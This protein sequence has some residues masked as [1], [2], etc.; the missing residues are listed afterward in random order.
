MK[1]KIIAIF[2][3]CLIIPFASISQH[4]AP[5]ER[6]KVG[7]VLSGGGAKGFAYIGLLKVIQ[8]AQ[9]PVD[10]IGGTSIGSIM[11]GLYAVGYSPE[12]IERVVRS[13]NWG[14]LLIDRIDR[15]YISYEEKEFGEKSI[16]T[17]PFKSKKLALSS[18]LYKGQ[19]IDLLLNRYFSPAYNISDFNKLPTPFLCI[20]TDLITGEPVEIRSGNLA[21]AIRASMSIPGYF[22]PVEYH[23][24][25]LCDGG[26][27][28]NFPVRNVKEMGADIIVAGDVQPGLR[29]SPEELSSITAILDQ[30]LTFGREDA[31]KDA[32]GLSDIYVPLD[33]PYSIMDFEEYD[34]LIAFGER[35]ARKH[36]QEIKNLADSLNAIEYRP[37][38]VH[39]AQPFDSVDIKDV[40]FK[41]FQKIPLQYFTGNWKEMVGTRVTISDI[42]K[43]VRLMY[44]TRFFERVY[45]SFDPEGDRVNL[46]VEVKEAE[47]GELGAALH[48]DND[49]S[50]SILLNGVVRNLLGKRSKVFADLV[51]GPN[52]RLRTLYMTDNGRQMGFGTMIDFYNFKFD[53]YD[54][55]DKIN[56][57]D[58]SNFKFSVFGHRV[59][60]NLYRWRLGIDY[61]L[62]RFRQEVQADPEL[63]KY[64]TFSGYGTL[65]TQFDADTRNN[66]RFPSKG[67]QAEAR[68]EYVLPLD[69]DI[70]SELFDNSFILYIKYEHNIPIRQRWV[71][72]PGIFAGGTL[73]SSASVPYQHAFAF[74][75]QN[76]KNYISSFEAFTGVSFFQRIGYYAIKG[77]AHLQYNLIKKVYLT[78]LFDVGSNTVEF[79]DLFKSPSWICG[80]G[81]SAGYDSFI[82]PVEL[83]LTGSNIHD[84]PMFFLSLG[85]WF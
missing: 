5:E 51:L 50:V 18:S 33:N 1:S 45:Y 21:R 68:L 40:Y 65:F 43:S 8:E 78:A 37:M 23:G 13:Q 31:N 67:F 54:K 34:S 81:I 84:G 39:T 14:D 62:F 73:P 52:P 46:V 29:K 61:E 38:P 66:N 32:Y 27:V 47:P 25:Y 17:L 28:N 79:D 4:H 71:F 85:Y 22:T 59:L 35:E 12:T 3:F 36:F 80:Y 60:N 24:K 20:G 82:G 44:G 11:G 70:F 74:G 16:V 83:T 49:Y 10:Y 15:K 56:K 6:P 76:P 69:K 19:E 55:A 9:L 42:E 57:I 63:K 53:I 48:Y 64:G 30:I 2:I 7:L 72:R 41:G 75:G 77:K 58:F 26:V